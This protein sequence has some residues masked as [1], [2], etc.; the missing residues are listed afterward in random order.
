MVSSAYFIKISRASVVVTPATVSSFFAASSLSAV[1]SCLV[2]VIS[3]NFSLSSS[4]FFW[5]LRFLVSMSFWARS[6]L[7][8]MTRSSLR[9]ASSSCFDSSAILS[10]FSFASRSIFW[11]FCSASVRIFLALSSEFLR[12]FLSKV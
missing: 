12:C 7:D 1:I 3:L 8:W 10:D 2:W 5:R 9:R 6:S 11:V 4:C